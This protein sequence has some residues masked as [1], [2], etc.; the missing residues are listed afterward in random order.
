MDDDSKG[1]SLAQV[2]SVGTATM[3]TSEKYGTIADQKDME[4]MGK[5]QKLRV[6]C[7]NADRKAWLI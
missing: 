3:K 2:S 6:G 4:R 1:Y 5:Q 7:L